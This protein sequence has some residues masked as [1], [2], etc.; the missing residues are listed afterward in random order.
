MCGQQLDRQVFRFPDGRVFCSRH[1]GEA[2][3]GWSGIPIGATRSGLTLCGTCARTALSRS[4]DIVPVKEELKSHMRQ[5]SVVV[6]VATRIRFNSAAIIGSTDPHTLGRTMWSQ[7]PRN[8]VRDAITSEVVQGLPVPQFRR[9]VSHE[10]AHAAI[11]G[12]PGALSL[13]PRL[14]EGITEALALVHLREVKDSGY[15]RIEA[16][17]FASPDLVYGDGLRLLL[18]AVDRFNLRAVLEALRANRPNMSAYPI[19]EQLS[20]GLIRLRSR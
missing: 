4:A 10:F 18:P 7:G 8:A 15:E 2:H 17:M 11:A 12:S 5:L 14:I 20:T 1:L 3:C 6:A 9:V 16:S 13:G 19:P